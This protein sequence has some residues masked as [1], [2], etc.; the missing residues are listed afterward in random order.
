MRAANRDV[1]DRKSACRPDPHP[2]RRRTVWYS[3]SALALAAAMRLKAAE[4]DPNET[5]SEASVFQN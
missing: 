5:F 1:K 3:A 4:T 2:A